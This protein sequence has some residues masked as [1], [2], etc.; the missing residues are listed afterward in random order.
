MN[1]LIPEMSFRLAV[2]DAVFR[3]VAAGSPRILV[4]NYP[5]FGP[6]SSRCEQSKCI[7][8]VIRFKIAGADAGRLRFYAGRT[9]RG[10][11]PLVEKGATMPVAGAVGAG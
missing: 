8:D 10:V 5:S 6:R 4:L 2:V 1:S 9:R 7:G 3:G 11:A